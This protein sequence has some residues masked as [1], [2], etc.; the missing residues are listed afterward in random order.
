VTF[1][2]GLI[3]LREKYVRSFDTMVGID[4]VYLSITSLRRI[5]ENNVLLV[6]LPV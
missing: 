2:H 3:I 4:I 5:D 1:G 6:D